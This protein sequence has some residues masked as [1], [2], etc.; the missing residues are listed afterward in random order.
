LHQSDL[1]THLEYSFLLGT[2]ESPDIQS[3]ETL[4]DHTWIHLN[5]HSSWVL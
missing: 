4:A 3:R 5:M 2:P 1:I